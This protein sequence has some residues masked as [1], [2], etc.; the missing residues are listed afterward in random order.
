MLT[1]LLVLQ[2]GQIHLEYRDKLLQGLWVD[3]QVNYVRLG[4]QVQIVT[5]PGESL[6]RHTLAIKSAMQAPYRMALSMTTDSLIY[7]VPTDE[8]RRAPKGED[9]EEMMCIDRFFADRTR[10]RSIDMIQMDLAFHGK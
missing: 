6:T 2:R 5:L 4:E 7:L 9:Y 3:T 8:W 10:D 1:A